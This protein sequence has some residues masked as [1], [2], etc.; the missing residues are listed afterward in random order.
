M[1]QRLV[2]IVDNTGLAGN[3]LLQGEQ[4][5]PAVPGAPASPRN[6]GDA[7]NG[8]GPGH[9]PPGLEQVEKVLGVSCQK[10]LHK[11]HR[12]EPKAVHVNR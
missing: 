8:E 1:A 2:Q 7:S 4:L 12:G 11:V 10:V 5:T 3:G 6:C 9:S